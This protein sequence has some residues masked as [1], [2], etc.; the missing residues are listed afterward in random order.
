MQVPS[1]VL[2]NLSLALIM[3][4]RT[5]VRVVFWGGARLPGMAAVRVPSRSH[6]PLKD[7]YIAPENRSRGL[8]NVGQS[9]YHQRSNNRGAT[10]TLF[11]S[12]AGDNKQSMGPPI[13]SGPQDRI[14]GPSPSLPAWDSCSV[15]HVQGGQSYSRYRGGGVTSQGSSSGGSFSYRVPIPHLYGPQTRRRV[16][17]YYKSKEAE[18][19][20]E[21]DSF[22]DGR[23]ALPEEYPSEE[24]S[25]GQSRPQGR[26]PDCAYTPV[27][28]QVSPISLGG[29]PSSIFLPSLWPGYSSE[30][31]H[32]NHETS[33]LLLE[34][35][36]P[37]TDYLH[38]RHP[39]NGGLNGSDKGAF[40]HS[41]TAPGETGIHSQSGEEYPGPRVLYGVSG[42][43][44][45]LQVH[46]IQSTRR[47]ATE[48]EEGVSTPSEQRCGLGSGPLPCHR[49]PFFSPSSCELCPSTLP[50]SA[51]AE[52]FRYQ[53][54][55]ILGSPDPYQLGSTAGSFVLDRVPPSLEWQQHSSA[56][57][58]HSNF[59]RCIQD[60]LGRVLTPFSRLR[61]LELL[62]EISA[63]QLAGAQ[64][65]FPGAQGSFPGNT[66]SSSHPEWSSYFTTDGQQD[67]YFFHQP[68]RGDEVQVVIRFGTTDMGVVFGSSAVG[69]RG[70]PPRVTESLSRQRV[71][72][73]GRYL[74]LEAGP[75]FI[76]ENSETMGSFQ[77]RP[78]C[79]E[80]QLPAPTIFQFLPGPRSSSSRCLSSRLDQ[81]PVLCFSSFLPDRTSPS[82]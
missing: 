24:P 51:E 28:P 41:D 15:I 63:H 27:P 50:C 13:Y 35:S 22:Q 65:S 7:Q 19:L 74:R 20:P 62:G 72:Q 71:S 11:A 40:S 78:L 39:F 55:W 2:M 32:E 26:I 12:L 6:T 52:T 10:K 82:L 46:G 76:Q 58:R 29:S 14:L 53:H 34:T 59:L 3:R 16:E 75:G 33:G 47:Q 44:S 79:S 68:Q 18:F 43:D 61:T 5:R 69:S 70:A 17:A 64:G 60:W 67:S 8:N 1:K 42:T 38:R 49:P 45:R 77:Y 31:L 56:I 81:F 80:T 37:Q 9:H 66:V 48:D 36:R 73:E 21:C 23:T 57:C 30:D 4:L 25:Y 54:N